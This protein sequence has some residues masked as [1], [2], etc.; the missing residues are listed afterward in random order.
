MIDSSLTPFISYITTASYL[1]HWNVDNSRTGTT[2]YSVERN[3]D[4][5]PV[6]ILKKEP[7][8]LFNLKIEP[9]KN[10]ISNKKNVHKK[11]T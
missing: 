2:R 3:G 7:I 6:A 8:F 10:T 1:L 11:M 5:A 4:L 9:L